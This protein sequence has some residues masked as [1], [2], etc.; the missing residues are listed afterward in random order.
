MSESLRSLPSTGAVSGL[1]EAV[2]FFRD[3]EFASRRFE[4]FGDVFETTLIGQRL[5]F[6]RGDQ[7]I[8]DLFQQPDAVQG[9]WPG[10]VRT[11]LGSRSLANR[12]GPDHKA[13]RRVVG[14]LFTTAALRRYSPK[15]MAMVNSLA[16]EVEAA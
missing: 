5:I 16:E 13:R 12:N 3:P 1:L 9:W 11:L 7:A 6:V 4:A 15:I 2:G 8:E 10:S 14:Q